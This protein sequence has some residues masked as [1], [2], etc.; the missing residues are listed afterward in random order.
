MKLERP[1]DVLVISGS[2]AGIA[3]ARKQIEG[4]AGPRRAVSA[5]VW[6]ELMRTRAMPSTSSKVSVERVHE[7]SG[8][9]L[10]IERQT[11]E[12]RIF[13]PREAV[14]IASRL[15]DEMAELCSKEELQSVD[16]DLL[17]PEVIEVISNA[18]GVTV[19]MQ[20]SAVTVLGLRNAVA[21][22]AQE[23]RASVEDP[24]KYQQ[25][26]RYHKLK[27]QLEQPSQVEAEANTSSASPS[28][29]MPQK[30]A[31]KQESMGNGNDVSKKLTDQGVCPTCNAHPFCQQCGLTVMKDPMMFAAGQL[32]MGQS[33]P[34]FA[35][36][37]PY[38]M[39]YMP[40]QPVEAANGARMA[41]AGMLQQGMMCVPMVHAIPTQMQNNL[42]RALGA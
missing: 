24:Q 11:K 20:D 9:R 5:E 23:L 41:P 8:C 25:S 1:R 12:V 17:E 27:S 2:Q 36:P 6:A 32:P 39:V 14:A 4:L 28:S 29:Q 40:M 3:A 34:S 26:K 21:K 38:Q 22:A 16:K 15:L 7:L 31:L 37:W 19:S 35:A 30:S 18:C 10:H 33:Q 42:D 13:G